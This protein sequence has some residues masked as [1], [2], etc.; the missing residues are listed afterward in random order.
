MYGFYIIVFIVVKLEIIRKR[1][2][3]K[4]RKYNEIIEK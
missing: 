4:Y 1:S 2:K 3:I